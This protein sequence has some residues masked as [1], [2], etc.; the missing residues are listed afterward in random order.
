MEQIIE[1]ATNHAVLVG[2]FVVVLSALAG[3]VYGAVF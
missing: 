2:A 1:F 3:F